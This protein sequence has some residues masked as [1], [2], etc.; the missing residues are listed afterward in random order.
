MN[1]TIREIAPCQ[2]ELKV[3][4]PR[5]VVEAEFEEVYRELKRVAQVPGFRV[6]KAPRNLLEQY[7]GTKARE[8]VVKRLIGRSLDEALSRQKDL[9]LI[10]S[11]QVTDVKLEPQKPLTYLARIEVA[12]QVGLS[13][14]KG[15]KLSR[16]KVSVTP[17]QVTQVLARLQEQQARLEPVLEPRS[18]QEKDFI[19]SNLTEKPTGKAP[20]RRPDVV[21]HLDLDKDPEGILKALIGMNPGEKRSV[22]LSARTK[23]GSANLCGGKSG[24]EII[25]EMKGLK[26]KVLPPLDDSFAKSV[27]S[28]ESLEALKAGIEADLKNQVEISQ[29]RA[30][31]AQACEQLLEGWTFDVP[32]SLVGSQ[33]KRILKEQAIE[34]M[35]R[36]IAA[37][38]VES[39]AQVLTDQAKM[40][41]LKQVKLFFILRRV[42]EGEGIS[43]TAQEVESKIQALA[44]SLS[45]PA[46]EVRQNLETKD[47]LGELHW[48]IT[49]TKVLEKIIQEAQ[50]KED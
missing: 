18:A 29:K 10:G 45:L 47:L 40:D 16:Q 28:F 2:K 24:G 6:G 36:G 30:L 5:D 8:E 34:M 33:A 22:Q 13:R 32:P 23:D 50:I 9:D 26:K 17:E 46:Q 4:L 43:A 39:Q 7:H 14:Y 38:Q 21:I 20:V 49:R 1:S 42:A 37:H 11:P 35:N 25:V 3:E 48:N 15:L 44:Q 19:L 31:E 41:A 12:P 27:G